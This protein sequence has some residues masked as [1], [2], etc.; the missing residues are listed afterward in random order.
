MTENIRKLRKGDKVK[1]RLGDHIIGFDIVEM[2]ISDIDFDKNCIRLR[3]Q[4]PKSRYNP[5]GRIDNYL[6][7]FRHLVFE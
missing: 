3:R 5:K 7:E 6:L 4:I 2:E 1:A